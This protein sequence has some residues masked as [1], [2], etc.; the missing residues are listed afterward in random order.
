VTII[1]DTYLVYS[2]G[3]VFQSKLAHGLESAFETA[4]QFV[5]GDMPDAVE[6]PE[7]FDQAVVF[8]NDFENKSFWRG[9]ESIWETDFSNGLSVVVR[10]E[11]LLN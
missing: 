4:L 9:G 11:S 1:A 10:V 8:K 3:E 2:E 5:F 6:D 7:L